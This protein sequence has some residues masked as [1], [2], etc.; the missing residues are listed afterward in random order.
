MSHVEI[1]FTRCQDTGEKPDLEKA[2]MFKESLN[3]VN[4][5]KYPHILNLKSMRLGVNTLMKLISI[6]ETNSYKTL[7]SVLLILI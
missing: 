6:L 2:K 7:Y 4:S 3:K 1:F 5:K